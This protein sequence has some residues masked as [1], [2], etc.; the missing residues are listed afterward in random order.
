MTGEI[1]RAITLTTY[2]NAYLKKE[3][4]IS[5]LTLEH[6]SFKFCN[7]TEFLFPKIFLFK[8][9]WFQYAD[10]PISWLKKLKHDGCL[11]IRFG[12]EPDNINNLEGKIVPDY[13]LAGFVG[14]GG[15][16]LIQTVFKNQ[17]DLWQSIEEVTNENSPDD[18]MWTIRFLRI[19]SGLKLVQK[20]EYNI[21]KLKDTM[22]NKL[23][24]LSSFAK[25]EKLDHW[26]DFFDEALNLLNSD[27]PFL[28]Y[29]NK[30]MVPIDI[31][32]LN[33]LQ[34]LS[35]AG[36][37][38]CFGGMGSWNDNNFDND[39]TTQKYERLT[40]E[41]YDIINEAYTAVSNGNFL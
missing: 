41:L 39:K 35:S 20:K 31:I 23:S 29:W 7:K 8:K 24:E 19:K 11:E 3:Y 2:G 18:R 5:S 26:S 13:K 30:D 40:G 17:T 38:W 34:L 36:K 12:F 14:G 25:N 33:S 32:K 1:A 37:A 6:P 22:R 16:H 15:K 10:N 27:Q 4:D 28:N 21:D 9:F